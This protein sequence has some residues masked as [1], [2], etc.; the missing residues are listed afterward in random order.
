MEQH[1]EEVAVDYLMSLKE[2]CDVLHCSYSKGQKLA[3]AQALPFKR[4]GSSW[5]I[6][7]SALYKSLG[8]DPPGSEDK[9]GARDAQS[10][11]KARP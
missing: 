7:R 3:K 10:A 8:L 6:A 11:K 4:I 5:M 1:R 9:E 2:A